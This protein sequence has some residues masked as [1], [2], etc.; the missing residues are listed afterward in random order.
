KHRVF[1]RHRGLLGDHGV[2]NS[3]HVYGISAALTVLQFT[4]IPQAMQGG[5][6]ALG[7]KHSMD[8]FCR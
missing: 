7:S 4:L 3:F 2:L 5:F 6:F 8:F 1:S